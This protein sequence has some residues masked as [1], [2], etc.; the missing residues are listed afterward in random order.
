VLLHSTHPSVQ[1]QRSGL[2]PL[3]LL[4]HVQVASQ[5]HHGLERE[6]ALEL[7]GFEK[8]AGSCWASMTPIA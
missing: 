7:V 1:V 8:V 2:D 4:R 5:R 3:F 6:L